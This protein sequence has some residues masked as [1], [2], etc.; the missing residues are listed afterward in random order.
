MPLNLNRSGAF[1]IVSKSAQ[2]FIHDIHINMYFH[3]S[4]M[5]RYWE[6]IFS[7]TKRSNIFVIISLALVALFFYWPTMSTFPAYVHAWTQSDRLAI[8]LCFQQNGFNL[9]LPCNFNLIT[10]QGVTAVDFPI[11]E[12][13]VALLAEVLQLEVIPLFRT[14]N[15]LIGLTGVF[16]LYRFFSLLLKS[17]KVGALVALFTL[18]L[19]FYAYYLNGFL[20][21]SAAFSFLFIGFYYVLIYL[22]SLNKITLVISIAWLTLAALIRLPFIIPLLALMGVYFLNSISERRFAWSPLLGLLISLSFVIGYGLYNHYLGSVYG[23]I[24]LNKLLS[25]TTFDDLTKTL[26]KIYERW[27][28]EYF[29]T[30]HYVILLGVV[31]FYILNY[32]SHKI[33]SKEVKFV[34]LFLWIYTIGVLC[35]FFAMGQQ[36]VDHDYYFLDTFL[37]ILLLWLGLLIRKITLPVSIQQGV[38]AFLLIFVIGSIG[39]TKISL[40]ERYRINNDDRTQIAY[41]AFK[42]GEQLLAQNQVSPEAT[43]LALDAYTTN[44]PFILLNRKGVAVLT[45]S[46]SNIV[47]ALKLPLDYTVMIDT[48]LFSDVYQNYPEIIY[49]LDY[50][51]RNEQLR[52]FE[53]TKDTTS[54]NFFNRLYH[55]SFLDFSSDSG[56]QYQGYSNYSNT[57]DEA[58]VLNEQTE[59]G[60]TYS[61][62]FKQTTTNFATDVVIDFDALLPDSLS[63]SSIVVAIENQFYQPYYLENEIDTTGSWQHLHFRTKIPMGIDGEL[64]V[65]FWNPD[66]KTVYF[67]N[68]R[69][70]IAQ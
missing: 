23:N 38:L 51:D 27:S 57:Q 4:I 32:S 65:Y 45:T 12:Y 42:S 61:Q 24:F 66:R 55:Y 15:L 64:K 50:I 39:Y 47:E 49:Q 69:L 2:L 33:A 6:H 56:K 25:I 5:K 21:S 10:V 20:P 40:K 3:L 60:L 59:F 62:Q 58:Q 43:V 35:F 28:N 30:Y 67:D 8:A 44:S 52:L 48:F 11:I 34:Q 7:D 17:N 68:F 13:M 26:I 54:I 18:T 29:T 46:D 9:F 41:K 1:F 19:P 37:P 31:I 22:K 53:K 16:Y 14:V 63:T 36:F 70:L